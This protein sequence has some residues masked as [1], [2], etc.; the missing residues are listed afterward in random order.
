MF[1]ASSQ[2]GPFNPAL[3]LKSLKEAKMNE[4]KQE[5]NQRKSPQKKKPTPK[6]Y[7]DSDG[8]S[9]TGSDDDGDIMP[10]GKSQKM[11]TPWNIMK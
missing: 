6:D 3:S 1:L 8:D 9:P 11:R 2:A 7:S 4:I 5:Q 10:D